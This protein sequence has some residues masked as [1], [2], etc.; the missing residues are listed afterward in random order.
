[1]NHPIF[2]IMLFIVF[3]SME[4]NNL[5]RVNKFGAEFCEKEETFSHSKS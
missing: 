2:T 1:M 4:S 3:I 5:L